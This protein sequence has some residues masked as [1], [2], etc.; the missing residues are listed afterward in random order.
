MGSV[1]AESRA[2]SIDAD[3]TVASRRSA[4]PSELTVGGDTPHGKHY[5]DGSPEKGSPE[6]VHSGLFSA[7][8]SFPL[9]DA[10]F[11]A[12]GVS[13]EN[14]T[15]LGAGATKK[16]V[17]GLEISLLRMWDLPKF[18]R[19]LANWKSGPTRPLISD[20]VGF[21]PAGETMLVLGR[22]GAGCSTLL[23]AIANERSPFVRIDG[24]VTYGAISAKEAGKSY[25]GEIV[26]NSEEDIFEPLLTVEQ[27][28]GVSY[29]LKKPH[30]LPTPM[31]RGSFAREYTNRILNAFGMPHTRNTKVGSETVRGVSGG[32]RKRVSLSEVLSTNASIACWDNSIRGLDSAV[33]LRFLEVLKELSRSTGMANIVSIYQT[34]QVMWETCF[35]RVVVI[36]DGQMCFSGRA[37]DAEAFFIEQGWV[38]KGRQ[39]TPDFLT[40]CTSVNERRMRTD[41][42]HPIPQS[43][44]EMA[45]YFRASPYYAQLV[46]DIAQYKAFHATADNSDQFRAA[47]AQ[48]KAPGAGK[49][50]QYKATFPQQVGVLVKRQVALTRADLPTFITRV[51][52]NIL[53]ATIIG[54]ICFKPAANAT[55]SYAVS[56]SIFFSVLYFTIFSF[57]EIPPTVLGRPLLIKHRKLGF[58]NPAAKTLAEMIVDAPVYAVQ[59]LIFS[60]IL[61]FLI[62]LN[63]GARYFFTFFFIVYTA[64][65][66]LSV[67]YR[68][69]ASWSPNLS[70]AVRFGGL[71]LGVV[72]TVAG[73]FLPAPNQLRWASWM[74]RISPVAYALEALLANEFR[75]RT[76]RCSATDLVP[77]GAG[78]GDIAYQGCTITGSTAG[79][80]VVSGADYIRIKYQYLPGNIW[81]NVGIMWAMYVI[82]TIMVVI[83]S[84]LLI[85]DTGSASSK[86]FKRGAVHV[87]SKEDIKGE[88]ENAERVLTRPKEQT[89]EEKA[90]SVAK[91]SVF[92]F[93]DVSYTVEVAGE[94]KV[95]LNHISG[96]VE[97][98]QL[99]ALMGAS[100][101]GKTTLLDNLARRKTTGKIEGDLRVDGQPLDGSF[102]KRTG[103]V[104]QGD[105]HEG[106]STVRECLQFSALL[107]QPASVSR[108]EKLAYAEE[109]IQLLELGPIADA[110]VGNPEIGG[111]GVEERK[112]LTIGVELAARPDLL[113]FLD[114][115]LDSQAAYEIVRFLQKIAQSG[116]AVLCTIHQPS[117]D[118]F[119]MFDAVV[120]LAPGGK[121]VYAGKTGEHATILTDYF[122]SHGIETPPTA[123]PPEHVISTVAPIGGT[124]VDWP[125]RWKESRQAAEV[126]ERID[127][128]S[129]RARDALPDDTKH[130]PF[131]ASY[132][133]QTKEL[134]IRNFR[135][136]W[137]QGD[138]HTTQLVLLVFF[139]MYLGFF[140]YKLPNS[141]AGVEGL[142]L[143]LLT[144]IQMVIYVSRERNGIYH[145]SSLVTSLLIVELPILMIGYTLLFLCYSF[146]ERLNGRSS[147][148]GLACPFAVPFVLSLVWNV[149]NG[150]S[151]SLVPHPIM[152]EPFHSFFS[153]ISPL[154]W[155]LG[156]LMSDHISPLKIT[157]AASELTRFNAPDG[158]TCG[159]YAASFLAT[160]AGYLANPDATSN[161]GYCQM[162][163]GA[164]YIGSLGYSYA[165]RWRDWGIF[166]IFCLSN[167]G[168]VYLATYIIRIRP[169]YK[170]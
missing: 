15:V 26:F 107:R 39:T 42:S 95:L 170:S 41:V 83:G 88:H 151:W 45:A 92:T 96:V 122:A 62:G 98:G 139:G 16:T 142:T 57:G 155:Y 108:E 94:D 78:Y 123:N 31:K 133:E 138:Y 140:F 21:V 13:F 97:P 49:N 44:A 27:T 111:L 154:R 105:I 121:T 18:I 50:N 120:L 85:R 143:S 2:D 118:L 135:A 157:C 150:L 25:G 146:A 47:V 9:P 79:S 156:S 168:A 102:N 6:K 64:Y 104:Q 81:R 37:S 54:A 145:W 66:A 53:Q 129:S 117:G 19:T 20:F 86:V 124:T 80:A 158:Q 14:L 82:Y 8:D 1:R 56:G 22:P 23:R 93:K 59:S 141:I 72:L 40:A 128:L 84:M 112:R 110:L 12:L 127:L 75:T 136:Q 101:A 38:K 119:E 153:W 99:T 36:F 167:I 100:G 52:S 17:E 7:P 67:M 51:V 91:G 160:A 134:V 147:V 162:S 30:T 55:G 65:M 114:E 32:E 28:L 165:H 132:Y 152:V 103:F 130:S 126:L 169:L 73:F 144:M 159:Q 149:W 116:L 109:V 161:C 58:Y 3:G 115:R 48:S 10:G 11:H 74:R 125:G 113:L 77:H 5:G 70:I 163:S 137:R 29:A 35:D 71:A 61:Y 43:P 60:S 131:A 87:D 33:A 63:S 68:M 4:A 24:E 89:D 106:F 69:I 90:H 76:L 148:G 166:I 164:D 46:E 34:S